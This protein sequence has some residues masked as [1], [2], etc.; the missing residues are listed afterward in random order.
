MPSFSTTV[1]FLLIKHSKKTNANANT[2][3]SRLLYKSQYTNCAGTE[4]ELDIA[5][6]NKDNAAAPAAA[7]TTLTERLLCLYW[8]HPVPYK[9][10][11]AAMPHCGVHGSFDPW[12]HITLDHATGVCRLKFVVLTDSCDAAAPVFTGGNFG[13][14]VEAPLSTDPGSHSHEQ[15]EDNPNKSNSGMLLR[16]SIDAGVTY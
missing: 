4:T 2:C 12:T 6:A 14:M 16:F 15:N 13:V 9:D 7:N 11:A 5:C 3:L 1:V 8:E 10:E